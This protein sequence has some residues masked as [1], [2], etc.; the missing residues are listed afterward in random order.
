MMGSSVR[1]ILYVANSAKIGGGNRSLIDLMVRLDRSRFSPVLVLP[2]VGPM[3]DW[4]RLAGVRHAIVPGNDWA[5][6]IALLRRGRRMTIVG[7]DERVSLVHTMAPTCYRAA[8]LVGRVL[9]IP[10]VCHLGYP[11]ER[12]E[13]ARSFWSGPEALVGCFDGQTPP[14]EAEVHAINP[15]CRVLDIS[16]GIDVARFSPDPQLRAAGRARLA[17]GDRPLVMIVGHLSEV[18]GYPVFLRAAAAV[19]EQHPECHFAALGGETV[20]VGYGAHLRA[21]A[22]ALGLGQSMHF[23]G[24]RDDVPAVMAAADIIVLPS[25]SEGLPL[26]VLEAMACG[27]P[28]IATPV[29][30]VERAIQ[31]G[32]SGCLIPPGEPAT[33]AEAVMRMLRDPDLAARIGSAAR[34]RAETE[35]SLDTFVRRIESLY[36]ELLAGVN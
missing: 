1:R 34:K 27:K 26:A 20:S 28:V 17:I 35:F 9:G 18:K 11:P 29:G 8:A 12:G 30:G 10:R 23:L 14:L 3:S 7:A 21:E 5:G 19:K 24:F 22:D 32:V 13:I 25:W 2:G 6:R 33:L 36:E 31:D 4:A 15:Q 16:N